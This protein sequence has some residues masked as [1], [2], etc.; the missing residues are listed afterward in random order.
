[1]SFVGNIQSSVV[2]CLKSVCK[3]PY[4]L[5]APSS[6]PVLRYLEDPKLYFSFRWQRF[7]D[8][9]FVPEVFFDI[10]A[11]DPFSA[12][13]QQVLFK[14]L[15]PHTRFFLFEAAPKHEAALRRSG[16]PYVIAL[17][18]KSDGQELIFYESTTAPAGTGDS[19]YREQTAYYDPAALLQ[20]KRWA[21]QLDR[22]V[23]EREWPLPDFMKLDT[24]GSELDILAGAPQ[25]LAHT[26]GIQIECS[27]VEYNEGAPQVSEVVA[28]MHAAGFRIYDIVQFHFTPQQQVLQADLLFL[29]GALV[30]SWPRG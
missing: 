25:C 12:E 21:R 11:N 28:F 30:P 8:Q 7:M 27:L 18:G 2:K 5:G 6:L 17:L 10:G 22:V 29:R 3:R 23:A 26:K 1:M 24:Q 14:P 19:C 4:F 16:E 13:G 15:L 20:E 9:C